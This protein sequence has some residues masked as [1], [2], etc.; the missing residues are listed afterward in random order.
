VN[1]P[2]LK[3]AVVDDIEVDNADR[4]DARGGEIQP[5]ANGARRP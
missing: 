2:P 5:P 4:T 3:V 1:D